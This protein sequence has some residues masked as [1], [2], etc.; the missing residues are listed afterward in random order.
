M[1]LSV[2]NIIKKI[3]VTEKSADLFKRLGKLT[4]EVHKESNKVMI[5]QAVEKIWSVKVKDVHVI[6]CPGKN[7]LFGRKSFK[8]PDKKKAIVTLKEGYKIE[9]PGHFET[10][11]V[12]EGASEKMPSVEGK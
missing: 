5:R 3:I 12:A 1:E 11:G 2:Y 8:S 7:K 9:L 6:K 10:M 4:F